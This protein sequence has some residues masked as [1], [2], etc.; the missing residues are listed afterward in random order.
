MS[1]EDLD[2]EISFY[3]NLIKQKPNFVD[4][5]IALGDVYTKKGLYKK[6]LRIDRRLSKL[7]PYD[8]IIHYNL[9]CDY[10]LLKKSHLC[11]GVL[12]KAIKLGYRDFTFMQKD[13][14]LKYIRQDRRYKE[15]IAKY[16][17]PSLGCFRKSQKTRHGNL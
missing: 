2:F 15:L 13:P 10:S 14:D 8:P 5:L 16:K 1:L 4:A 12:K 9:A 7:R 3:E 6:G 17:K 11:L